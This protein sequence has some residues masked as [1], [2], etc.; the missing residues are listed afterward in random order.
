MDSGVNAGNGLSAGVLCSFMRSVMPAAN[1]SE[2]PPRAP[3]PPGRVDL[4]MSPVQVASA[5][6]HLPGM[7]FFDSSGNL[8]SRCHAPV[9]IIAARPVDV[10]R[11]DISDPAD[12]GRLRERVATCQTHAPSLGF[13]M[14]GACGWVDYEGGYCFGIYPEMLVYQHDR[15][16]WWQ[17]GNLTKELRGGSVNDDARPRIGDFRASMTRET[18]EQGVRR[19]HEYIAAG[20]IYQ[21]NLTQRFRAEVT[22]TGGGS[23]FP[24]YNHLREQ[25]P[26]PL[27][28]WMSLGDREVLSSSPETYLRM[29]GRS[30]ET[31]PIKGTRPRSQDPA[32]DG[33]AARELLE[34]EKENAELVMITDLERNDLG[35]VCEFGSVRVADM[36]ALEKLEQVYHLVST[37]TGT[38]REDVDHIQALAA[39]FPGGS[40]TGAPK[41]RAMEIIREL[42]PVPRGLYTGAVGYIGFNG[43]SQFN[44]P[45]RTLVREA[46]TLDYHVGAGIV[47]DSD[48]AA[49]Y[50]E[51]QDK[52]RGIRLALSK[53]SWRHD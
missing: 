24:L 26:A 30:I 38:L 21:V 6:R 15:K 9:S 28:A 42:E 36:L 20:D 13:P 41:K 31:R 11:G 40:I 7:V 3:L 25:S 14:G 52:A 51:T 33:A 17:C 47:A 10:L 50:R 53:M 43:E 37:V 45:I 27:A 44:I 4:E 2:E 34:S 22:G 12:M 23:L 19:I 1:E 39:C 18:Y 46:N 35:Q 16:Q 48:A 49:E 5:L 29:S 32:Q 8:P